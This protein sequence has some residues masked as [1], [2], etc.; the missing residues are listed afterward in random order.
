MFFM[1]ITKLLQ[2]AYERHLPDL[3]K[4]QWVVETDRLTELAFCFL[5]QCTE[6]D[7][8]YARVAAIN[9]QNLGLLD[10]YRLKSIKE[11]DKTAVVLSYVLSRHGF[12]EKEIE[13]SI[14]V[15]SNVSKV[16]EGKFDGKVQKMLREQGDVMRN[17]LMQ[18]F[19]N[20]AL[21]EN[22]L[23]YAVT[24]W[25]QNALSFPLSLENDAKRK[26]CRR[27]N[28]SLEQVTEAADELDINVAVVDDLL[29]MEEINL[30]QGKKRGR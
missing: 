4:Y 12:K 28:I 30:G 7:P 17:S 20:N 5:T 22:E 1:K 13:K 27:K 6:Q 23:K 3:D 26:F 10:T 19:S 2:T 9:L 25:M 18:A 16:I 21:A 14:E 24:L 8:K 11:F 15:L 29:E